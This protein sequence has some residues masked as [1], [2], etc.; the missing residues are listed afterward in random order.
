MKKKT[1]PKSKK[2][3]KK[4]KVMEELMKVFAPSDQPQ[5]PL[6]PELNGVRMGRNYRIGPDANPRFNPDQLIGPSA[7]REEIM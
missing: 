4:D 1:K 7:T 3:K 6:V 5:K 2:S